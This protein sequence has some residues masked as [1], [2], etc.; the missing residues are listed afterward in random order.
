VIDDAELIAKG[1]KKNL[2]LN[3]SFE[4]AFEAWNGSPTQN[5]TEQ[6]TREAHTGKGAIEV[7]APFSFA[8]RP[9]MPSTKPEVYDL[10]GGVSCSLPLAL[11][12]SQVAAAGADMGSIQ[13]LPTD[14]RASGN[15]RTTRLADII[16]AW[17]VMQHF[18][19]YFDVVKTDW[20]AALRSALTQA[21]VDKNEAAFETTL[22]Q[23]IAKLHDGHGY[24]SGPARRPFAPFA[25]TMAN[26]MFVISDLS[27]DYYGP[28]EIGDVIVSMDGHPT[29]YWYDRIDSITPASTVQA[30]RFRILQDLF[31]L[32]DKDSV[33]MT[34][35]NRTGEVRTIKVATTSYPQFR[36]M[37]PENIYQLKPGIVY[38]NLDKAT[39]A[40]FAKALPMLTSAKAIVCDMRGYPGELAFSVISHFIDTAVNSAHW[41]IPLIMYPDGKERHWSVEGWQIQPESPRF[42]KN[43]VHLTDGRAVSAA[44]TYMGIIEAY[45]I[46]PIVGEATAGTNGNVNPFTLPGKY[47]VMWTGMKVTKHDNSQHHGVGIIPTLPVQRSLEGI[48]DGRDEVLERGIEEAEKLIA[49]QEKSKHG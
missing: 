42:T 27:K 4:H 12:S 47:S 43:I 44:E 19:P 33:E 17:N 6:P 35:K 34:I 46:G 21:A 30:A 11:Y 16:I 20:N 31:A 28:L 48:R 8:D 37:H 15:D 36:P 10:G 49:A 9:P 18:Y 39:S 3:P 7:I 14:F 22:Q 25:A 23:M 24:V 1:S 41:N 29:Q 40:E 5:F 45:K 38:L 2:L 13:V 32:V 26:S